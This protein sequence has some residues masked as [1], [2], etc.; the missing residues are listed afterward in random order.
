MVAVGIHRSSLICI[1]KKMDCH[2]SRARRPRGHCVAGD[3]L[4]TW[5]P[6]TDSVDPFCGTFVTVGADGPA[7][8]GSPNEIPLEIGDMKVSRRLVPTETSESIGKTRH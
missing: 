6:A 7:P 4:Q 3:L 2:Q 5:S 8:T 1:S